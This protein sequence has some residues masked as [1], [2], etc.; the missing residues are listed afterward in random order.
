MNLNVRD[1]NE[2]KEEGRKKI[3]KM[4]K[5]SPDNGG[6]GHLNGGRRRRRKGMR[7]RWV[8][9]RRAEKREKLKS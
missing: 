6:L 1:G 7:K 5:S 3:M 4:A 9:R 8:R 2:E